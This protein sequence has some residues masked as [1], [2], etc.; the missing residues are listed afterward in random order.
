MKDI[1]HK[2]S[3]DSL[4]KQVPVGASVAELANIIDRF[5]MGKDCEAL[6]AEEQSEDAMQPTLQKSASNQ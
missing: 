3:L 6:E 2:D 5:R 4:R 1:R